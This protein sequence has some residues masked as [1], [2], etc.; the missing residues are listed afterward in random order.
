LENKNNKIILK[1]NFDIKKITSFSSSVF[2][3]PE[4][5]TIKKIIPKLNSDIE[6]ISNTP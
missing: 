3:N 5:I 6:I 2:Y 4:N 1:N